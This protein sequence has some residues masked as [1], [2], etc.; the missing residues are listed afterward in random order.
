MEA[1]V[2]VPRGTD[3]S[4]IEKEYPDLSEDEGWGDE[5]QAYFIGED[6]PDEDYEDEWMTHEECIDF[7]GFC[8]GAIKGA[9]TMIANNGPWA[10]GMIRRKDFNSLVITDA[11]KA[12]YKAT[13]DRY[14]AAFERGRVAA[15]ETVQS[16]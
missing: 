13:S 10:M 16:S 8:E 2:Y 14:W 9:D 12:G 7:C 5:V 1:S 15:L 3:I 4:V 6:E 11:E